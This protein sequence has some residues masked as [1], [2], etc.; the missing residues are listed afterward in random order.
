LDNVHRLIDFMDSRGY[1]SADKIEAP[2]AD[3]G[4]RVGYADV[5]A[6]LR[7]HVESNFTTQAAYALSLHVSPSYVSDVLNG[8]REIPAD[9]VFGLGYR[10][11]GW[12]RFDSALA[13]F[14]PDGGES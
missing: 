12:E 9:W 8:R 14:Q 1:K 10:K 7:N 3:G 2:V 13:K 5:L 6:S 4:D 11:S